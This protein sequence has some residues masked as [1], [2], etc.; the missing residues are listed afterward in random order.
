[1]AI[2]SRKNE[3]VKALQARMASEKKHDANIMLE[4][5]MACNTNV[6]RGKVY[7]QADIHE[8]YE[9]GDRFARNRNG[10]N[11]AT[12][13]CHVK[14]HNGE[15]FKYIVVKRHMKHGYIDE[16]ANDPHTKQT[17]NQLIDEINCWLELQETESADLLCPI[18]KYFTSKSDKVN[19]ISEKMQHNVII[20]AQKAVFVGDAEDA[21]EEAARRNCREG[22]HGE[23]VQRRYE[24]MSVLSRKQGWRDAMF[25]SGNSGVIF[26]YSKNC[27][28]AV[29]IDYAL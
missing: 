20:I 26:D 9:R 21:C 17:G 29:F 22:Y 2:T 11:G 15:E 14:N 25:N 1:M 10:K 18:L 27:Y 13:M 7:G 8:L 24:K 5:E 6:N 4:W 23:S 28:K 3:L 12:K 19:A 16:H